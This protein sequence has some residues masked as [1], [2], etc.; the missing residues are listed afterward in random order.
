MPRVVVVLTWYSLAC[1]FGAAYCAVLKQD[2]DLCFTKP[3]NYTVSLPGCR[4]TTIQNNFCYG[5][6]KSYSYPKAR[7][8]G[9]KM[10][11][12]CSYCAPVHKEYII[13]NIPCDNEGNET[14]YRQKIVTVF[15]DCKCKL[16]ICRSWPYI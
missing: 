5:L 16:T 10:T 11:A 7:R 15:K 4:A 12:V 8:Y 2:D 6:C 1:I 3:F 14:V 9:L 13:V